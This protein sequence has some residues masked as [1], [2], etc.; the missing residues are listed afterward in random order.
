MCARILT[1]LFIF[2]SLSGCAYKKK[3]DG[4][5]NPYFSSQLTS[6]AMIGDGQVDP[7]IV[8]ALPAAPAAPKSGLG[9]STEYDNP[10]NA[11]ILTSGNDLSC[12]SS[13]STPSSTWPFNDPFARCRWD[14]SNWGQK[15]P[16]K[17]PTDP[18]FFVR[19]N[20]GVDLN[21]LEVYKNVAWKNFRGAGLNIHLTD[22]GLFVQHEDLQGKV[23]LSASKNLCNDQSSDPTP[24]NDANSSQSS[25]APHGTGVAGIMAARANNNLG[26]A[27]IAY[28]ATV[29]ADNAISY[30]RDFASV[31]DW[32]SILSSKQSQI[33]NGSFGT[34][35]TASTYSNA[36]DGYDLLN[37][38]MEVAGTVDRKLFFK[39]AGNEG[40]TYKQGDANRDPFARNHYNFIIGALNSL[41]NPANYTN[42]GANLL[43]SAFGGNDASNRPGIAT[44]D[45]DHKYTTSFNGT[46][47]SAPQVAAISA[48]LKSANPA[49]G[50]LD[51]HY[52]LA[53]T[54]TP[55]D[56]PELPWETTFGSK[57]T[58]TNRSV[59]AAGFWFNRYVGFG[60][61]DAFKAMKLATAPQFR[62]LPAL[63]EYPM[64]IKTGTK[65]TRVVAN[66]SCAI[67]KM[68]APANI[69]FQI[70]NAHISFDIRFENFDE[71]KDKLGNLSIRLVAPD[72]T[73]YQVI[74]P[75]RL[76]EGSSYNH[77][78]P[79]MLRY[80]MGTMAK[81]DYY[82]EVCAYNELRD[83]PFLFYSAQLKLSGFSSKVLLTKDEAI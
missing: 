17:L 25:G 28:E 79:H 60:L 22:S 23:N 21:L 63:E 78:Q 62:T 24:S 48:L 54:A 38:A 74:A 42:P 71:D 73:R 75:S 9:A 26:T 33:W 31:P 34:N 52:I 19:G 1:I 40:Y 77:S 30:C 7:S 14:L 32:I 47:A 46:S 45:L 3:G 20:T 13:A 43:V 57:V 76:L 50:P 68:T 37:W 81:G 29:S 44:L 18:N 65:A 10:F 72:G 11:R 41:G 16:K 61:V 2:V 53:R 49:L 4:D 59:N 67:K 64:L 12:L 39:A 35:T 15:S 80:L 69:T 36:S 58:V 55:L 56:S 5:P 8:N 83:T 66:Q 51:I 82:V 27:G 6:G 70:L